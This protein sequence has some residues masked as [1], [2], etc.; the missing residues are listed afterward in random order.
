MTTFYQ[1]HLD[2]VRNPHAEEVLSKSNQFSSFRN[3]LSMGINVLFSLFA[4]FGMLYYVAKHV[5]NLD[6]SKVPRAD[7]KF[8]MNYVAQELLVNVELDCRLILCDCGAV[9]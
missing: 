2:N 8:K 7:H 6:E 4:A 1:S 5:M 9:S 3:Q